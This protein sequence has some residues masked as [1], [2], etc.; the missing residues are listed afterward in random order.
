MQSGLYVAQFRT[1]LDDASG[2]ICINDGVV[3]G[4]DSAMYYVGE[5]SGPPEDISVRLLV[6][7]HDDTRQSVF[8]DFDKFSLTLTGRREGDIFR[9]EGRADAAPS[10][11]F[12]AVLR[13]VAP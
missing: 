1:P 2:V 7:Q 12:E 11:R 13:Q 10:M 4:G 9:F 5:V 8:G 3:Y 6:T